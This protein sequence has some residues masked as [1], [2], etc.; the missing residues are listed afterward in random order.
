MAVDQRLK[1]ADDKGLSNQTG[2]WTQS[3]DAEEKSQT[4][5]Q[6]FHQPNL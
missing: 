1:T 3:R 5:P 4:Q 6:G 2:E